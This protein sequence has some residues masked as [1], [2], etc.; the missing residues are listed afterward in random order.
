[1]A[2]LRIMSTSGLQVGLSLSASLSCRQAYDIAKRIAKQVRHAPLGAKTSGLPLRQ[3][4][5][6]HALSARSFFPNSACLTVFAIPE[7][8]QAHASLHS[9]I[10]RLRR[11]GLLGR[12]RLEILVEGP[13]QACQA[14]LRN[15]CDP[16]CSTDI[17]SSGC[18]V[19]C[20]QGLLT[21]I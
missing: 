16:A 6:S 21:C 15:A 5:F 10:L 12:Q 18:C 4:G 17:S 8:C 2:L 13:V 19:H 14:M 11:A 3:T 20:R 1:M 7:C 9:Q